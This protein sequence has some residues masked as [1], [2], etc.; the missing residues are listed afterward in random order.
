MNK[1]LKQGLGLGVAFAALVSVMPTKA[2]EQFKDDEI[3]EKAVKYSF[4]YMPEEDDAKLHQARWNILDGDRADDMQKLVGLVIF[5]M[6]QRLGY[7][8]NPDTM[9][10]DEWWEETVAS[11]NKECNELLDDLRSSYGYGMDVDIESANP[12]EAW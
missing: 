1:D 8:F 3:C 7:S 5:E 6:G 4:Q 12:D 2:E 9:G 11:F 10:G